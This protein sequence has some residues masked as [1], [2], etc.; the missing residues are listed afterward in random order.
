V[1]K[2]ITLFLTLV[3]CLPLITVPAYAAGELHFDAS[4]WAQDELRKADEL[5][6][7]PDSLRSADLTKPIT[8]AEFAAVAVLVYENLSGTKTTPS[9]TSAFTDTQDTDVLKAH[10]T[11]LMAGVSGDRFD[12]DG[13]LTREQAATAL[14]RVLKRV[15][16]PE[17]TLETD[18][19][20]KLNFSDWLCADDAD[21]SDW[22]KESV[23]FM[24]MS[25]I[26]TGVGD[27]KFAPKDTA[28]IEAAIIIGMRLAERYKDQTLDL[29]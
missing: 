13:F 3:M 26:I 20:F 6:L 8:R 7:I 16:I 4:D 19:N 11:G 17:W 23:Y 9:D 22:A 12:P 1:K 10:N 25:R 28:T 14:T 2:L 18:G 5:E 24:F 27:N 21:I 29:L 15:F